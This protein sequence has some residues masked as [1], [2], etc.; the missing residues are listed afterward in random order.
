ML[1]G[2]SDIGIYI[3]KYYLPHEELAKARGIPKEKYHIGLGNHNMAIIPNW[4]DAVTMGANAAFQILEA[5]RHHG[6]HTT[7]KIVAVMAAEAA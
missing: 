5:E 6:I 3:P 2:V 1:A 7:S 4:E